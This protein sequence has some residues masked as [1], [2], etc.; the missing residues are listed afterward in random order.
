MTA[1][2]VALAEALLRARSSVLVISRRAGREVAYARLNAEQVLANASDAVIACGAD[3]VTIT[4]WN[5][6]AEAMFGWTA[7]EIL[8]EQL[9]TITD[10]K[11]TSER[12]DLLDRVRAGEQ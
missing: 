8:G 7:E 12:A 6:A 5:P 1:V 11:A 2:L 9:P 10:D 3:G 4:A